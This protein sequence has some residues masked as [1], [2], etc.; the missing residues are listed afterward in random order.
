MQPCPE[1]ETI[2]AY[3]DREIS[4]AEA[5]LIAA[6]LQS[7]LRCQHVHDW[8]LFIS[9]SLSGRPQPAARE[10]LVQLIHNAVDSAA[11]V[12]AISCKRAH[13]LIY[14]HLDGEL[15]AAERL[16]LWRHLFTCEQCY[17]QFK[18]SEEIAAVMRRQT[19]PVPAGLAGRIYNAI[20]A[21]Q[22]LHEV[23]VIRPARWTVPW[24]KVGAAA[25]GL[26]AAA[27]LVAGLLLGP[28]RPETDQP[29]IGSPPPAIEVADVTVSP[30]EPIAPVLAAVDEPEI[31]T[32]ETPRPRRVTRPHRASRSRMAVRLSAPTPATHRSERSPGADE[33]TRIAVG[34]MPVRT[35]VPP[36]TPATTSPAVGPTGSGLSP[37]GPEAPRP[38][39]PVAPPLPSDDGARLAV[40]RPEFAPTPA[41][42]SSGPG[43]LRYTPVARTSGRETLY[44]NSAPIPPDTLIAASEAVNARIALNRNYEERPEIILK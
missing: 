12:A 38:T 4:G 7:C 40:H 10:R 25:A 15:A 17:R 23:G 6:H 14:P 35:P 21:E 24:R 26:A 29:V 41:V 19:V 1:T 27:A 39:T 28:P 2:Q 3:V 8:L 11:P 36:E 33:P 13:Q 43:P 16:L 31:A 32:P 37:V 34:D 22:V 18:Q 44:H 20:E 42:G 30:E 5:A 9:Q